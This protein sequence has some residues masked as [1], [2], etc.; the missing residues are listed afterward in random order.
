MNGIN[1]VTTTMLTTNAAL[2]RLNHSN[3][4]G[5]VNKAVIRLQEIFQ[6]CIDFFTF[7][8][9][10]LKLNSKHTQ[11]LFIAR[12][13]FKSIMYSMGESILCGMSI[14]VVRLQEA[15]VSLVG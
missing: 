5:R 14:A 1:L 3:T 15:N 2:D 12:K 9:I 8:R 4:L 7:A 13:I 6:I 11:L 10:K